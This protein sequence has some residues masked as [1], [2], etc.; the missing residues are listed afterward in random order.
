VTVLWIC[1]VCQ[2]HG[3]NLRWIAGH[4]QFNLSDTGLA[5]N[6]VLSTNLADYWNGNQASRDFLP[7]LRSA[8]TVIPLFR[9]LK[10]DYHDISHYP[11]TIC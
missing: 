1:L 4:T 5:V 10:T 3:F 9:H 11:K 8:K 7:R 2:R 6:E